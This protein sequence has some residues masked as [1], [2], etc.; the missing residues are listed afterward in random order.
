MQ[1]VLDR[2][3][4]EFER[5][6]IELV[7]PPV[8]ERMEE[9]ELLALIADI[10]GAICGDDRF[11]ERVMRAAPRLKVIS[12]WGTGIDSIDA[13]AAA[14]LGIAVCR[15]PDAFSVPVADT[16]LGYMLAFARRQPWMDREMKA[17]RWEKLPGRTLSECVLGVIGVGD[18]GKAVV[19]HAVGVGMTVLGNDLVEMPPAFL[20]QTGITMVGKSELLGRADFVS[21]NCDLNPTSHHLMDDARFAQMQPHAVLI[22]AARGPVVHEEA[23][24]RALQLGTIAGAALD[25]FEFEPLPT[26]SPLLGMDNVMLAPHNANS[27]PAAWDR[28]HR[29]TLDNL[30]AHLGGA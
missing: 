30:L 28:V 14:R 7:V 18:A 2:F 6:G 13:V 8:A 22:N 10:D 11:T 26:D 5:E 19:R 15:T 9:D 20:E 21:V 29:S 25:V 27:S 23:L 3:A 12:K 4:D 24:V 16:V 1:P 17:G